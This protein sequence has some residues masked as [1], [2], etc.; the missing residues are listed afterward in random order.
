MTSDQIGGII[1]AI[2]TFLAG[3]AVTKGWV[4]N[5]T[6]M[7]IVGGV[8]TVA[9]AVWSYITNKPGKVLGS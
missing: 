6:A 3:I 2:L 9:V 5:A 7:T 1:R 4:D 8:V